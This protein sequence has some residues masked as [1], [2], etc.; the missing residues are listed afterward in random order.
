LPPD[1]TEATVAER[2]AWVREAAGDRFSEIEL[3][4]NLM[5]V[6]D[7]VPRQL[8]ARLDLTAKDLAERGSFAAVTGT[9]DEMCQQLVTRRDRLGISYVLVSDELMEL[10]APVV[11][12]L[13]GR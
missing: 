9:V 3:N 6:G 5:A 1:A 11:E 4:V 2:I 10:F 13:R 8:A 12:R 7:Q